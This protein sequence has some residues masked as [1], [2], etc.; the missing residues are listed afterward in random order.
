MAR[1]IVCRRGPQTQPS[2]MDS[3]HGVA[4]LLNYTDELRAAPQKQGADATRDLGL[5]VVQQ[6]T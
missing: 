3:K 6:V 2:F 1:T 4:N 5:E